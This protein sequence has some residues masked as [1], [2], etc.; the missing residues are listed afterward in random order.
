MGLSVG[1]Q[2][3]LVDNTLPKQLKPFA[4]KRLT[5]VG[6]EVNPARG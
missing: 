4:G 3:P 6:Y 5:L 1:G 2:S